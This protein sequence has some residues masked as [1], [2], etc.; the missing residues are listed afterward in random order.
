MKAVANHHLMTG[1]NFSVLFRGTSYRS[2]LIDCLG[3]ERDFLA[4]INLCGFPNLYFLKF[5][6][7]PLGHMAVSI[8]LSLTLLPEAITINGQT[9]PSAVHQNNR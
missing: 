5:P 1:L 4:P 8:N 2:F 3:W 7:P 6:F 9:L